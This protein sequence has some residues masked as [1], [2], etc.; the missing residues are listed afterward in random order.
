[1]THEEKLGIPKGE[2]SNYKQSLGKSKIS[3]EEKAGVPKGE[4]N[5]GKYKGITFFRSSY[6]VPQIDE[7]G[8][9]ILT[10]PDN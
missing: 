6:E 1:L 5:N 2:R 10:D 8:F 9:A 3:P 7:N 4:R